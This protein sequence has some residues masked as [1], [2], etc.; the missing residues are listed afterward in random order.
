[1]YARVP[2][3]GKRVGIRPLDWVITTLKFSKEEIL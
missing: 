1:M 2:E 3:S